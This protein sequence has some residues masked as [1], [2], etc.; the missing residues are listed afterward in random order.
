M[1]G[2]HF[3]FPNPGAAV[4]PI[5][6]GASNLVQRTRVRE[7]GAYTCASVRA[8]V[9]RIQR[10]FDSSK[11]V[12]FFVGI[13]LAMACLDP[14]RFCASVA[15]GVAANLA[16]GVLNGFSTRSLIVERVGIVAVAQS[17]F[18][19]VHLGCRAVQSSNVY[20]LPSAVREGSV[21]SMCAGFVAGVVLVEVVRSVYFSVCGE[22]IG[23]STSR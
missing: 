12:L 6:R 15:A 10:L 18:A 1:C 5:V 23:S 9:V 19:V 16:F 3:S 13:S 7:L 11:E 8:L 21:S 2:V 22:H 4:E 14:T 20:L 17:A